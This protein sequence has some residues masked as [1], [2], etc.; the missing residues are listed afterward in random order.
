MRPTK[1]VPPS[2]VV[3]SVVAAAVVQVNVQQVMRP[4]DPIVNLPRKA[5]LPMSLRLPMK[6]IMC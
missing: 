4:P 1:I 2:S 5:A 3:V 6:T